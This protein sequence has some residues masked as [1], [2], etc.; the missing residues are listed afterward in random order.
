[1]I[2]MPVTAFTNGSNNDAFDDTANYEHSAGNP[3][4]SGNNAYSK[5]QQPS[6][7]VAGAEGGIGSGEIEY[8]NNNMYESL[9]DDKQQYCSV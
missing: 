2:P 1:M 4:T 5:F 6:D 9:S 8:E 7:T 3:Q